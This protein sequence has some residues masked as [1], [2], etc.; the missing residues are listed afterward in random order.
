MHLTAS[1]AADARRGR[2]RRGDPIT[3]VGVRRRET[4]THRRRTRKVRNA[5]RGGGRR[6]DLECDSR[7]R[8]EDVVTRGA[9]IVAAEGAGT[10][11]TRDDGPGAVQRW[12]AERRDLQVP[13]E[14]RVPTRDARVGVVDRVDGHLER[15]SRL[16][17][18]VA[19]RGERERAT[20]LDDQGVIDIGEVDAGGD[21]DRAVVI[22]QARVDGGGRVDA[23]GSLVIDVP[24]DRLRATI[25]HGGERAGVGQRGSGANGQSAGD[26][27]RRT[28]L[29]R[30]RVRVTRAHR[31]AAGVVVAVVGDDQRV[32]GGHVGDQRVVPIQHEPCRPGTRVWSDRDTGKQEVVPS[33]RAGVV[34]EGA[35]ALMEG[36]VVRER[37]TVEVEDPAVHGQGLS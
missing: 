19:R 11:C 17:R 33:H 28:H 3:R 15:R 27:G 30:A 35:A 18:V 31:Q 29:D 22:D 21:G 4:P 20:R 7:R 34:V 26:A 13:G 23:E 16:L 10:T 2:R 5:D 6:V 25:T 8:V 36:P 37:S 24:C 14:V 1:H 9:E 32:R 12:Q